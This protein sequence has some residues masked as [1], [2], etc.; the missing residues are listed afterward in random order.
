MSTVIWP[1]LSEDEIIKE[2]ESCVQRELEWLLSALQETLQSLKAGLE[3]C[4]ALLAPRDIGSTLVL[5]SQRSES[6]KGFVT[7]NGARITKGDIQLRLGSLMR[8]SGQPSYR[9]AISSAPTAPSLVIEQLV[10]ARSL[11][12]NC[13]DVVDATRWT[14]D[15]NNA[16]YISSQLRLLH[17]NVQ[18]AR[19][20]LKGGS[21]KIKTWNEEPLAKQ[22]FEPPLPGPVS[23]HLAIADAALIFTVRTLEPAPEGSSTGASTPNSTHNQSISGLS[24]RDRLAQA[25]GAPP[26]PRHDEA[27]EV[28]TYRNQL[29]KVREKLKIETQDPSLMA[30]LAKLSALEHTVAL[31]RR[32]LDVVMGREEDAG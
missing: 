29:V 5:S 22:I 10:S 6:L 12:N 23:L 13:L 9:L 24:I 16:D 32:A 18:E 2:R 27:D 1:P 14:G 19:D 20:E 31:S 3:E 7:L 8:V 21:D 25:L 26:A 28:F 30:A 17:E 15:A 4:A 11:I